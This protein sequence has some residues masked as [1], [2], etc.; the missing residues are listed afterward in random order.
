MPNNPP[1]AFYA[2]MKSPD[3][4]RPSGDRT[5]ARLFMQALSRAGFSVSLASDFRS[6]EGRGDEHV[7]ELI[8]RDAEQLAA[9]LLERFRALPVAER[10]IAW[11]TYHLYHKSPDLLGPTVSRGLGIPYFLA[12]ASISPRQANGPWQRGYEQSLSAVSLASRIFNLN[13][14]DFPMLESLLDG[15]QKITPVAP[16]LDN[17]TED[18]TNRNPLRQRLASKLR[19]DPDRYWLLSVAMMRNDSKLK[20]YEQLAR[21]M[22]RMER[23]DWL[24]LIVGDGAAELQV[25][26]HFRLEANR[27]IYFL[28]RR[29]AGFIRQL[30]TISDLLVWPAINEAIGMITLEALSV[31]LPAVCGRSGGIDQ[32][33][34]HGETGLLVDDPSAK[35]S[36]QDFALA[37]ESLLASPSRLS[38]MAAACLQRF[39]QYHRIEAAAETLLSA[40]RPAL[41]AETLINASAVETPSPGK[42]S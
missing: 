30:M 12:E 20:S 1:L 27:Q 32:I 33:V 24:L 21:A 40:M 15:E 5:L 31:G 28:G 3:S 8:R 34:K 6:W 14:A 4:P 37:I 19:L 41:P 25:R 39:R 10:P 35:Q 16:F 29:D 38:A 42:A 7:Q 17:D 22:D 23:K 18:L 36:A 2:P 9:S 26:D 13:P 11:F